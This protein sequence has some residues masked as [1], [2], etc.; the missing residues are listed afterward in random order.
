MKKYYEI[1][2]IP[3]SIDI[4]DEK[5]YE[6]ERSLK[7]FISEKNDDSHNFIF[8]TVEELSP[9]EGEEVTV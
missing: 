7:E 9:P 6:D 1:A 4:P 2:G 5:M 3:I 8:T